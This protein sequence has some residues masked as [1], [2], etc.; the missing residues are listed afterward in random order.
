MDSKTPWTPHSLASFVHT[1]NPQQHSL[2]YKDHLDEAMEYM[3][4]VDPVV[5][6][7]R[8]LRPKVPLIVLVFAS[9]NRE[10]IALAVDRIQAALPQNTINAHAFDPLHPSLHRDDAPMVLEA[11]ERLFPDPEALTQSQWFR[12]AEWAITHA[13]PSILSWIIDQPPFWGTGAH[14][15]LL[16]GL[17]HLSRMRAHGESRSVLL[18]GMAH[19]WERLD[20]MPDAPDPRKRHAPALWAM[21]IARQGWAAPVHSRS[22]VFQTINDHVVTSGHAT[23][24]FV[25]GIGSWD[26]WVGLGYASAEARLLRLAKHTQP[27]SVTA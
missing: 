21:G 15:R 10:L 13:S 11:W 3:R 5:F 24:A 23:L 22:P 12:M 17:D 25:Q 8:F 27:A 19:A 18:N 20:G 7:Q 2:G 9:T 4:A 16:D 6:F 26:T 14:D 1:L